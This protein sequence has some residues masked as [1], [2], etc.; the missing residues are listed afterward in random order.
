[1][2]I[3]TFNESDH[4]QDNELWFGWNEDNGFDFYDAEHI[5]SGCKHPDVSGSNYIE[6]EKVKNSDGHDTY[7]ASLIPSKFRSWRNG[8]E[9]VGNIVIEE[10][11]VGNEKWIEFSAGAPAQGGGSTI[12][13]TAGSSQSQVSSPVDLNYTIDGSEPDAVRVKAAEQGTE[14]WSDVDTKFVWPMKAADNHNDDQVWV[15]RK[16][17]KYGWMDISGI[18]RVSIGIPIAD[19]GILTVI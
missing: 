10:R 19:S 12:Y 15:N 7:S 14:V 9:D 17:G 5:I 3:P 4:D 8:N 2:V 6:V 11:G 1:M 13:E 18:S 16:S